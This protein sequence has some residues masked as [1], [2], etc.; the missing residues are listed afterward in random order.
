MSR[1]HLPRRADARPP[2]HPRDP[3]FTGRRGAR[4]RG[5]AA[6]VDALLDEHTL[7]S[8]L[9]G[10]AAARAW[11]NGQPD[12][13]VAAARRVLA[14][15]AVVSPDALTT[16]THRREIG[17]CVLARA[18]FHHGRFVR[19]VDSY[20]PR[21]SSGRE[22][23]FEWLHHLFAHY[24]VPRWTTS[25]MIHP[26]SAMAPRGDADAPPPFI[27]PHVAQGDS[28]VDAGLPV[29]VTR[30]VAHALATSSSSGPRIAV[31]QAQAAAARI[32]PAVAGVAAGHLAMDTFG[33]AAEEALITRFL[34]FLARV[35]LEYAELVDVCR[36][37]A[38]RR[39]VDVAFSFAG[40][41]AA[42]VVEIARREVPR[43]MTPSRYLGP[44]PP[45]GVAGG[46]FGLAETGRT[47]AVREIDS[48]IA[49]QDEGARM[50]HCVAM[51][52]E[53]VARGTC[54]IFSAAPDG[55]DTG[56]TIEVALPKRV[57]VQVKGLANRAP[58]AEEMALLSTW[59]RA[60]GVGLALTVRA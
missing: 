37:V 11:M 18:A 51:Y 15:A 43:F 20:A 29:V 44:F 40:R 19:S 21:A 52:A 57:V 8:R 13:V 50:R 9:R 7:P 2:T 28:Y 3:R 34:T 14:H 4:A 46:V 27:Y 17:A 49:L 60:S 12:D 32:D 42:S 58:T 38:H 54:A 45:S 23:L 48:G 24:P 26:P 6:L 39:R 33:D 5:K 22:Q 59:S 41:T 31:R 35:R 25:T 30:A 10:F 1:R 55:G 53:R 16:R 56:V 36:F 47:W